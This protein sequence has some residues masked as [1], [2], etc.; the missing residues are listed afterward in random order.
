[1][2][3]LEPGSV[4]VAL[5]FGPGD[6]LGGQLERLGVYG[7]EGSRSSHRGSCRDGTVK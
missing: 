7:T 6:R 3:V 4:G 1:M 5:L 2:I